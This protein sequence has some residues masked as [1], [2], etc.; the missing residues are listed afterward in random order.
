ML[1][2]WSRPEFCRLEKAKTL[3]NDKI[4]NLSK[5]KAFADDNINVTQK[6]KVVFGRVENIVG[7]AENAGDQ[8]QFDFEIDVRFNSFLNDKFLAT[9]NLKEFADN[10]S[11]Y[12]AK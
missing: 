2:I 12:D 9:P 10:N 3:P 4:L 5:F 1:S 8:F 11:K 6:E 7:K